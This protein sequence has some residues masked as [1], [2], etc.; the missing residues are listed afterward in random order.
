MLSINDE[1]CVITDLL[2]RQPT[3]LGTSAQTLPVATSIA[4]QGTP[5][6]CGAESE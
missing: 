5:P 2:G 4:T 6:R 3:K 1:R